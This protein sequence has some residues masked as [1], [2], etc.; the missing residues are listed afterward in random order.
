MEWMARYHRSGQA[1]DGRNKAPPV[2][3]VGQIRDSVQAFIFTEA[4]VP[5]S[6]FFGSLFLLFLSPSLHLSPDP[7]LYASVS[8]LTSFLLFV[9][10]HHSITSVTHNP[11]LPFILFKSLALSFQTRLSLYSISRSYHSRFVITL[12]SAKPT[13]RY[14]SNDD[15]DSP[16]TYTTNLPRLI[17]IFHTSTCPWKHTA[18]SKHDKLPLD[19]GH[20]EYFKFGLQIYLTTSR[21]LSK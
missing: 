12:G 2:T 13:F 18:T 8:L 16:I 6:P 1:N 3:S 15:T 10:L 9:L 21:R 4:P 17:N 7:S 19:L 14:T 11:P 5:V 20:R